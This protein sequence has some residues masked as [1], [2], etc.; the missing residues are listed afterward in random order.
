MYISGGISEMES[1]SVMESNQFATV[2]IDGDVKMT[3]GTFGLR[4]GGNESTPLFVN[5]EATY[6]K[7]EYQDS[8]EEE[9]TS[10]GGVL[11]V[12]F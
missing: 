5:L 1:E 6:N 9:Q 4:V 10:L 12:T 3:A 2:N 7:V 11:G 8:L